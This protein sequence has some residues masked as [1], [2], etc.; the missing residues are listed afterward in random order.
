M[1]FILTYFSIMIIALGKFPAAMETPISASVTIKM[2]DAAY[3][4]HQIPEVCVRG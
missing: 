3:Y 1:L 2:G 4:M